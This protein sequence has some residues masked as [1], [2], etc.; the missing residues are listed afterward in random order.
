ME[1]N[2]LNLKYFDYNEWQLG[3]AYGYIISGS[4]I[5]VPKSFVTDLASTPKMLWNIFEP[6][7]RGY[8]AASIVH[9]Y[10]YSSS[11]SYKTINRKLA[12]RIFLEIMKENG[13]NLVKR[14]VMYLAVRIFGKKYFREGIIWN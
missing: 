14:Q 9:D 5:I 4:L 10:L 8:L 11:C 7:G 12:D 2:K 1:I 3:S 6:F 13:V